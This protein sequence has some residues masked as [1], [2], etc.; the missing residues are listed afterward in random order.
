MLRILM[1]KLS[2]T[3]VLFSLACGDA[4]SQ[5]DGDSGPD[6]VVDAGRTDAADPCPPSD[7]PSDHCEATS[8]GQ[9]YY[10]DPVTGDDGAT[11]S[12][13]NPWRSLVNVNRSIYGQYNAPGWVELSPGDVVYLRDGVYDRIYHPGDDSGAEGGGSYI[14]FAQSLDGTADAPIQLRRFPGHHPIF[15]VGGEGVGIGIQQSSHIQISGVEVRNGYQR[16][17]AIAGSEHIDV[18]SVVVHDT[19]ATVG[20]NVAGLE[21]LGSSDCSVTGSVFYDNYDRAAAA[22]G[23]Q[24][25]NSCNLVLFGGAGETLVADSIFYQTGDREGDATGCGLKYKHAS[26]VQSATFEARN[27]YFEN[28]KYF[29][30]GVG[31]AN[32]HIHH[33]IIS[34]A[35]VAIDSSD[36]G[37]PTHQNNQVFEYNTIYD[38]QGLGL[39]PTLNWID[40]DGGP[41]PGLEDLVFRGNIVHDTRDSYTSD[42]RT[43]LLNSYMSDALY[44]ALEP[45]IS[46]EDNCYYN[47]NQPA[48]FGFAEAEN[49]GALG[50]NYDLAG[51]QAAHGFDSDSDEVD[52]QLAAPEQFDFSVPSASVCASRGALTGGNSVPTDR[53]AVF[54]CE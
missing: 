30:I 16:G 33:N 3:F 43:V 20:A 48:S 28:H 49:F 7:V 38:A 27:N 24:T 32:A 4:S 26:R 37:G 34:G 41:W 17:I 19:D 35:P 47:P 53:D 36:H 8:S 52:P 9:C 39:S 22:A 10:I 54:A 13:D 12:H 11:G 1:K 2:L 42:R 15:D 18:E 51:W 29:A 44:Q 21:L 31:T 45:A 14:F 5:D 23:A 50:A 46:F 6:A 40:D 25:H